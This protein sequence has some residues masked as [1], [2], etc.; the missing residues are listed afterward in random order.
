[1]RVPS[2]KEVEGK[3]DSQTWNATAEPA[4]LT[5]TTLPMRTRDSAPSLEAGS[6]GSKRMAACCGW[7]WGRVGR[8]GR[9][10]VGV[11]GRKRVASRWAL[12]REEG[13]PVGLLCLVW[14]V[15]QWHKCNKCKC[16][17]HVA[18]A[19][20]LGTWRMGS[21][22]VTMAARH[23]TRRP[24]AAVTVTPAPPYDTLRTTKPVRMS[25]TCAR[26]GSGGCGSKP[27][28]QEKKLP[29][30]ASDLRHPRTS[31]PNPARQNFT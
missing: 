9:M 22:T 25:G 12:Q 31:Y 19:G 26:S 29:S 24:S 1:M 3:R 14:R 27:Q 2:P 18:C 30:H 23:V 13:R 4:Q 20:Y 6:G 28:R 15:V 21:G 11:H 17:W 8:G 10:G 16:V 5:L 7:R